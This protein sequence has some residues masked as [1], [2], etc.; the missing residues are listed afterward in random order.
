VECDI[1]GAND[2]DLR[3]AALDEIIYRLETTGEAPVATEVSAVP[4]GLRLELQM[5]DTAGLTPVGAIP[6][7]VSPH[8]FGCGTQNRPL[9]VLHHQRF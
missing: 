7:A 6:K 1:T 3:P 4:A 2:P 8:E 9:V 5:A